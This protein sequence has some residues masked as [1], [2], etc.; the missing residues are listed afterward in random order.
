M[1]KQAGFTLLELLV[2]IAVIGIMAA[3][4]VPNFLGYLPKYRLRSAARDLYSNLHLVK[5]SAIKSNASWAIVFNVDAGTYQVCS[6][7]GA[8]NSWGGANV[9]EKTVA[10]SDY[11]NSVTYG[12]G[13]A[14]SPV[15]STF[16][17]G[18]TYSSPTDVAV[19]NSRGTSNGGYV[20]L[21]DMTAA[22]CI[23]VGTRS[24]GVIRLLKW[25]W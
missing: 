24:S 17:N 2:V 3:I 15:G 11:G 12:N 7:K 25:P 5:M 10:L 22:S 8:D 4:A 19:L 13:C 23:A 9:V 21:T 16:G 14:A 1:R 18:V 20:Y 6:G